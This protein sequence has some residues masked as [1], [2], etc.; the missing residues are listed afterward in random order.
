[1][2]IRCKLADI[3]LYEQ[4]CRGCINFLD[5]IRLFSIPFV[6]LYSHKG[7]IRWAISLSDFVEHKTLFTFDPRNIDT[8]PREVISSSGLAMGVMTT[9]YWSRH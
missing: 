7:C 1:M 5:S 2:N 9:S 3:E 4:A 6:Q 8:Y